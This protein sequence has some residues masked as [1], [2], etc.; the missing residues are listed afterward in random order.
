M[1]SWSVGYL[2]VLVTVR[3]EKKGT[4][5]SIALAL[6]STVTEAEVYPRKSAFICGSCFLVFFVSLW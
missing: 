4:K 1:A 5:K 2:P 6:A 3:E